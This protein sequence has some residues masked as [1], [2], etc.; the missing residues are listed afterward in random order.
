MAKAGPPRTA[1]YGLLLL[2]VVV[3]AHAAA[4]GAG[5]VWDDDDYVT[6]NAQLDDAQ[7]LVRIW[8]K[9]GA[10]PQYYPLVHTT[11][12]VE[13]R[14]WGERPLGY[15]AV[16]VL[17]H[18][19]NALLVWTILRRLSVPGAWL[20]AALFGVHPVHAESVAWI[21]A[22][23]HV[24][25]GLFYLGSLL[26][27]IA[28]DDAESRTGQRERAWARSILLF[29][30]ALLAKTVAATLPAATLVLVWWRRGRITGK[31]VVP[32]LPY[33]AL[34]AAAGLLTSWMERFHV[35][36]SGGDWALSLPERLQVAGRACWFYLGKLL[37][38]DPLLFIYPRWKVGTW[39]PG[40]W[41]WPAAAAATLV[42][43]WLLRH[44]VGRGPLA[45]ALYFGLTL[46]PAL[47]FVNVYPMRFSYVADHF[48]Y[49]ASLGPLALAAAGIARLD[50]RVLFGL[51]PA[52]LLALSAI[53]WRVES[54][55]RD[56]E[57]LWRRTIAR[58]PRVFIAQNN[59]GGMLL[60][61]GRLDE[62]E[63]YLLRAIAI[64]PG[65][66]EAYDNLG[67]VLHRRGR[68][69]EAIERYRQALR[70]DPRY[71]FAH[72]NLGISLAESGRLGE[73]IA[74]FREAIRLKPDFVRA[75][76]NLGIALYRTGDV[77]GASASLREAARLDPADPDVRGA[78]RAVTEGG[79]RP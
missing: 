51:V 75:H 77:A 10:V 41:L 72:N 78:L 27:W 70:A 44:R 49:L 3:A 55:Y 16:N 73:A 29:V 60:E 2:L 66:P 38:P 35:G 48:Q 76:M 17:L 46:G 56:E 62:A 37:W 4:L 79:R 14:L 42:A 69:D 32:T 15:H 30:F 34:G 39:G 11:F 23:K 47:G 21:A 52:L 65:Y 7:G 64:E 61:R 40:A 12:W 6:A 50:R 22:R 33:F 24:L 8:T 57:T 28:F 59:L 68:L 45:A 53:T 19:G 71:S 36:A 31:D 63:P 9:L 25:S 5:F 26:A 13:H 18:A 54:S 20:A 1:A 67:I 43:L 58:D 74:S